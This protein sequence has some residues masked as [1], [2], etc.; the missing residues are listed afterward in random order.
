VRLAREVVAVVVG[1]D[2]VLRGR[3]E[4]DLWNAQYSPKN[5][6]G[7]DTANR[8]QRRL[9]RLERVM[10]PRVMVASAPGAVRPPRR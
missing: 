2:G 3:R 1:V 10:L 4:S 9:L 6:I 5:T 8:I 7:S